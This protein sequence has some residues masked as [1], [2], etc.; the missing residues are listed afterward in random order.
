MPDVWRAPDGRLFWDGDIGRPVRWYE[1]RLPRDMRGDEVRRELLRFAGWFRTA[2][3]FHDEP[4]H[5]GGWVARVTFV[6]DRHHPRSWQDPPAQSCV[7]LVAEGM[8]P[9]DAD[10]D[11]LGHYGLSSLDAVLR[12]APDGDPGKLRKL[13]HCMLNQAGYGRRGEVAWALDYAWRSAAMLV[14]DPLH[15]RRPE[16]AERIG[17]VLRRIPGPRGRA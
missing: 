13:V 10:S 11:V 6:G 5:P 2:H 14:L 12:Y 8:A 9:F 1:Y 4:W 3:C 7:W 16:L 17:A 15:R